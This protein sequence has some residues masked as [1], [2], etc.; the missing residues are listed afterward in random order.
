[1]RVVA[2]MNQKGGVGKTTTTINLSD[3]LVRS[4]F[5]VTA[6]DLDPQGHLTA[7]F[8]IQA[9]GINGMAEVLLHGMPISDGSIP[10]R[11][12]LNL[13]PPGSSLGDLEQLSGSGSERGFRLRNALRQIVGHTDFILIDCPPSSGILGMNVLFS[14]QEILI[15]VSGDYLALHGLSRFMKV[16][17]SVEKL[18]G[19]QLKKWV[20]L[21]RFQ[22][23]RR[24]ANEVRDKL[25]SYFAKELLST[26]IR[27]NVALAECPS[28]GQTI[29]EYQSKSHGAVD[30]HSLANDL[31]EERTFQ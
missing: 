30:Y 24:L 18:L 7:S 21:T 4:G 2:V 9:T 25:I 28:F 5:S 14:A 29:F 8:G 23:R 22:E 13:I 19:R 17:H 20:V 6:V 3:A 12:N 16:I 15:P 26:A 10:V 11:D 27:E 31:L 1:M